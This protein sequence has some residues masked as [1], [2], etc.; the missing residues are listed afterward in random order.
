MIEFWICRWVHWLG[1]EL[2]DKTGFYQHHDFLLVCFAWRLLFALVIYSAIICL[3][4]ASD[5]AWCRADTSL[6]V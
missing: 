6:S 1:G 3:V 2:S 4:R 5:V